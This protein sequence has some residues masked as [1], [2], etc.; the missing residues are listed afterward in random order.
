MSKIFNKSNQPKVE[1]G[2]NTFDLSFQNNATFQLGKIYPVMCK[3]V[4]PGDTFEIDTAFGLRFMPLAFPIQT[5]MRADVHYFYCRNRNGWKDWMNFIGQTGD[6]SPFPMLSKA[7]TLKHSRTGSLGDYLGLPTTLTEFKKESLPL[8]NL[9]NQC[10]YSS[11]HPFVP[12]GKTDGAIISQ[13]N[14]E[15]CTP[16]SGSQ[17]QQGFG[18][19]Y[20]SAD[21]LTRLRSGISVPSSDLFSFSNTSFPYKVSQMM[22]MMPSNGEEQSYVVP[23]DNRIAC[24]PI[25][26]KGTPAQTGQFENCSYT[27]RIG[28]KLRVNIPQFSKVKGN[29]PIYG[30]IGVAENYSFDYP[31]TGVGSYR[32]YICSEFNASTLVNGSDLSDV[33]SCYIEFDCNKSFTLQSKYGVLCVWLF[34]CDDETTMQN[35]NVVSSFQTYLDSAE[36]S[37]DYSSFYSLG[38]LKNGTTKTSY[39][40]TNNTY[41]PFTH[42]PLI[43]SVEYQTTEGDVVDNYFTA[44][45]MPYQVSAL[46]F[47]AYE[48]IYNSFYRDQRNNPFY[49]DGKFDPNQ[50]TFTTDGGI[51]DNNYDF[52]YRNWEQDF[53]TSA[54][55][56]PQQGSVT[57]LVGVTASGVATFQNDDGSQVQAQLLYADDGDTITGVDFKGVNAD[58]S[59]RQQAM[60][61]ASQGISIN[62]FRMVNSYQRW[63]ETNLRRGLKYKDQLMSHFGVDASYEL[64]DM[65]E[66]IGGTSQMVQIDQINQTSAGTTDDPLGSYAAQASCVGGNKNKITKYC[67][68]HGFIIACFSIVPTPCYSQLLPKHFTKTQHLDYFFPEFGHIGYQPITYQEVCPL[69]AALNGTD[70]S[71]TYGY[72]RAWYDYLSSTDEVHGQFRTTLKPFLLM[73][74]Y[75]S[76]PSI[77]P[78]FLLVNQD[79][80]NEVFTITEIDGEPVDVCLGQLHFDVIVKRKIPRFGIPRLE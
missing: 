35:G 63:L 50:Y 60:Q 25:I 30:V 11:F 6:V 23:E 16:Y 31:S 29:L 69:Q 26:P 51:D 43:S 27:Y 67:D 56:T 71:S 45:T 41:S 62:D 5:K 34:V 44:E 52:H 76:L 55:L 66:F 70:L 64:L 57:P 72:Q 2:R 7:Q 28:D 12:D 42:V 24:I 8:F 9:P 39:F 58:S 48:S 20:I 68:E 61:L 19:Y 53:L 10:V 13:Y 65:P 78:E 14:L 18:P 37:V 17:G 75:H 73:R 32:S 1:I 22:P 54:Q 33:Q 4:L 38:C 59:V 40:Y 3:E 79:Q 49:V 74:E 47:R 80:L 21:A 46:P 77:K 36:Q 15:H